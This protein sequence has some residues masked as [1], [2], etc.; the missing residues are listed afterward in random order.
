VLNE[1]VPERLERRLMSGIA[2]SWKDVKAD[3]LAKARDMLAS[4]PE[5]MCEQA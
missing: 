1:F 5:T 4:L 2:R 3:Q